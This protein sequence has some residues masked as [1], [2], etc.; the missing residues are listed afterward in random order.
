MS[1]E[2]SA[3]SGLMHSLIGNSLGLAVL[4]TLIVTNLGIL[5]R[6]VFSISMPWNEEFVRFLFVWMVFLGFAQSYREGSLAGIMFLEEG[7]YKRGLFRGYRCVKLIQGL[8]NIAFGG[9]CVYAGLDIMSFQMET[10]EITVVLEIP[11]YTITLGFT[12]GFTLFTAYAVG[13]F[14]KRLQGRD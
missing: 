10:E 11:L 12:L 2:K 13:D 7:L 3:P 5:C 14:V 4:T 9:F 1:E 8:V 6:Y